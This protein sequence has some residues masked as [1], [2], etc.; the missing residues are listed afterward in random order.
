MFRT[1]CFELWGD[2]PHSQSTLD[3][4]PH[5]TTRWV[6]EQA[7]AE[8]PSTF[9]HAIRRIAEELKRWTLADNPKEFKLLAGTD[10]V[11]PYRHLLADHKVEGETFYSMDIKALYTLPK[12]S[13]GEARIYVQIE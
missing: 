1:K 4:H 12:T 5:L 13:D 2:Y 7:L 3:H 11:N 10:N 9:G 6:H 8:K